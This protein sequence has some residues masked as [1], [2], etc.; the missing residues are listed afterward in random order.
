MLK[1]GDDPRDPLSS[2]IA[3]TRAC[4]LKRAW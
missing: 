1:D 2:A 4:A 3:E